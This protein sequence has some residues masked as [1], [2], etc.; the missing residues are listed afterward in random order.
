MRLLLNESTGI[1]QQLLQVLVLLGLEVGVAADMLL[2]D[3]DVGNSPLTRQFLEGILNR[4]AILYISNPRSATS[5]SESYSKGD[6][7]PTFL[8]QLVDLVLCAKVFKG[9]LRVATVRAPRFAEDDD[10]VL[11]DELLSL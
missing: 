9:A 7:R 5:W 6:L 3:E 10:G 8:V 1:L 11:V 2:A 4:F